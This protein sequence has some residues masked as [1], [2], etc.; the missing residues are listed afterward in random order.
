M[1]KMYILVCLVGW[2][3]CSPVVS[4]GYGASYDNGGLVETLETNAEIKAV[5][6]E[7]KTDMKEAKIINQSETRRKVWKA[8]LDNMGVPKD[9]DWHGYYY[10]PKTYGEIFMP[11]II[12]LIGVGLLCFLVPLSLVWKR[13]KHTRNAKQKG[14]K[15]KKEQVPENAID[16]FFY[17][18]GRSAKNA[19]TTIKESEVV[20]K[21]VG[22][23]FR[24][25]WGPIVVWVLM[26]LAIGG[27]FTLLGF[28]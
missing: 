1:K 11:N 12:G 20:G 24:D 13:N 6:D 9:V 8:Y 23:L 2:L 15:M 26:I 28:E 10:V 7:I 5:A 21:T 19:G 4:L 3:L 17:K 27:V 25:P 14:K 16:R 18:I 22:F